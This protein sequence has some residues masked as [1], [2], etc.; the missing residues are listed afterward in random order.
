MSLVILGTLLCVKYW[1]LALPQVL[2]QTLGILPWT[3]QRRYSQ[4]NYSTCKV[5][6]EKIRN[7]KI[8]LITDSDKHSEERESEQRLW[9]MPAGRWELSGWGRPVVLRGGDVRAGAW[10]REPPGLDRAE[11]CWAQACA[12]PW[13][14]RGWAW[15]SRE[16]RAGGPGAAEATPHG[17]A[18]RSLAFILFDMKSPWRVTCGGVT[19]APLDHCNPFSVCPE[20]TR[21]SDLEPRRLPWDDSRITVL[22]LPPRFATNYLTLIIFFT[23]VVHG[24]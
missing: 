20:N 9:T 24:V 1:I 17:A 5:V 19:I 7:I 13:G 2:F 12:R 14:A 10:R 3:R 23:L 8:T 6:G 11:R 21:R 18:E 22:S 15:G 4:C 16:D